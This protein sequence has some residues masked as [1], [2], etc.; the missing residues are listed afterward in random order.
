MLARNAGA[1]HDRSPSDEAER[2]RDATT[3]LG[4]V[5]ELSQNAGQ[6]IRVLSSRRIVMVFDPSVDDAGLLRTVVQ[7]LRIGAITASARRDSEGLETAEERIT[8]AR[9]MLTKVNV[10]R[11]ASSSIRSNT[12]KI[13]RECDAVRT[14]IDRLLSQA[15][16]ALAGVAIE[17]AD[18]A[19]SEPDS[20]S[21]TDAA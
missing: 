8:E 11:T 15:L 9:A 10:I 19:V 14:G 4:L 21:S 5:R 12:N 6:S 13:D 1:G 18:A 17:T 16:N 7:L 2:N 20:G 3:S